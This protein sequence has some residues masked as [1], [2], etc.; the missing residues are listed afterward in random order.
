MGLF[1]RVEIAHVLISS[2]GYGHINARV[3]LLAEP[4]RVIGGRED[5]GHAVVDSGD[6]LVGVS[7]DD[8]ERPHPLTRCWLSPV[9][10]YAGEAYPSAEGH[11][12]R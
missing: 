3:R 9:L 6:Q 11:L 5:H 12:V 10:P 1:T 2:A 7:G 4:A 8:R